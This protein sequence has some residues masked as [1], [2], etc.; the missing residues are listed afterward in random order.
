MDSV[1]ISADEEF[2][3]RISLIYGHQGRKQ[4]IVTD[5]Q[6][7]QVI[8]MYF[9]YRRS[10]SLTS[11]VTSGYSLTQN[12]ISGERKAYVDAFG[13]W[14]EKRQKMH[15]PWSDPATGRAY[16]H[17]DFP[18]RYRPFE[19]PTIHRIETPFD[20]QRVVAAMATC[21]RR[22]GVFEKAALSVV[23][24]VD[25][26]YIYLNDMKASEVR[27]MVV[28]IL[29][30]ES[31]RCCRWSQQTQSRTVAYPHTRK[32][33]SLQ[34]DSKKYVSYTD[35]LETPYVVCGWSK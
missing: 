20:N 8:P 9:A 17:V 11:D 14:H 24:Y 19:V 35:R 10:G 25:L 29:F 6:T 23:P 27:K 34:F 28:H 3:A 7:N 21:Q 32:K 13:V 31:V 33:L 30:V 2:Y 22:L 1:R 18:L 4:I 26:L 16:I 12:E 15:L 5:D